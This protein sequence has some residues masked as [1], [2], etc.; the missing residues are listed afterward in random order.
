MLGKRAKPDFEEESL[1]LQSNNLQ[2]KKQFLEDFMLPLAGLDFKDQEI[3]QLKYFVDYEYPETQIY[4]KVF[5]KDLILKTL[6]DHFKSA[7]CKN[8]HLYVQYRWSY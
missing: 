1:L 4:L 3:F 5:W 8:T 2:S 7:A 6:K